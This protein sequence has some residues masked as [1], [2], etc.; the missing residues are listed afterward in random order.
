MSSVLAREALIHCIAAELDMPSV[1]M[2]GPSLSSRRKA[3]RIVDI[4]LAAQ[5]EG[6]VEALKQIRDRLRPVVAGEASISV[7]EIFEAA[8]DAVD[9]FG[10]GQ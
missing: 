5:L 3:E 2:S 6:A 9:E 8:E 7:N 10:R 1:Y 4:H